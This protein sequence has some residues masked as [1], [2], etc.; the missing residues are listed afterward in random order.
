MAD[1]PRTDFTAH[2]RSLSLFARGFVLTK[3]D[4]DWFTEQYLT[5]T[6]I[7]LADPRV[8]PVYASRCPGWR[9]R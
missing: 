5:G 1:L 6:G 9:P 8:S 4:I 7:D 3:R 2:T